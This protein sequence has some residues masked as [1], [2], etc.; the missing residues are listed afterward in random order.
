MNP[1]ISGQY[2]PGT[3]HARV[4]RALL[5]GRRECP[6]DLE[7]AV[8]PEDKLQ[9]L[10][11]PQPLWVVGAVCGTRGRVRHRAQHVRTE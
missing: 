5:A 8:L 9:L 7:A 2:M 10:G 6:R 1:P 11:L 3:L 4:Q